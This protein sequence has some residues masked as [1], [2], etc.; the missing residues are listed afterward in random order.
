V[1]GVEVNGHVSTT[2]RQGDVASFEIQSDDETDEVR[3]DFEGSG[4]W[5][6]VK[7]PVFRRVY[8]MPGDFIATIR[9]GG[10][11]ASVQLRVT[12]VT[13]TGGAGIF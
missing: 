2:I 1:L 12:R 11:T 10:E 7:G 4:E 9:H 5:E 3:V 13:G 6:L 8:R